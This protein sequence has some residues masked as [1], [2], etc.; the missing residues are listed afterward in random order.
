MFVFSRPPYR[1]AFYEGYTDLPSRLP[2]Q[3]STLYSN[4]ITKFLL[5]IGLPDTKAFSIDLSDEVVR[6]S[7]VLRNGEL[8]F[9]APRPAA[10]PPASVVA[11][12]SSKGPEIL[13]VTPWQKASRE[14][15][16][17]TAGMASMVGLG[18]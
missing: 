11:P 13:A 15:A 5:S 10:P 6:G 17:V 12:E 3:S 18:A 9:P 16:V 14:V 8:L 1:F 2:T 4:N 7:I